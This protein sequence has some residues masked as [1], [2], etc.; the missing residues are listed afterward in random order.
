MGACITYH[1]DPLPRPACCRRSTRP[2]TWRFPGSGRR[3]R[4]TRRPTSR[5]QTR[6]SAARWRRP[7][8]LARSS[9]TTGSRAAPP[10]PRPWSDGGPRP[11]ALATPRAHRPRRGGAALHRRRSAA[12]RDPAVLRRDRRGPLRSVTAEPKRRESSS[13]IRPTGRGRSP[14]ACPCRGS[15]RNRRG[16]RADAAWADGDGRLS[17]QAQADRRGVRSGGLAPHRRC[18]RDRRRGLLPD[19]RSQEGD[20][21]QLDREEHRPGLRR[22]RD[23]ELQR[24]DR[25]GRLH[26]QRPALQHGPDRARARGDGGDT[27]E[28]DP[29]ANAAN[30]EVTCRDQIGRPGGEPGDEQARAGEAVQIVPG[31]WMPGGDELTP[32]MKLKRRPIDE[33]HAAAI[34]SLYDPDAGDAIDVDD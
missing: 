16:R 20:H 2:C 18:L 6:T 4:R 11:G 1:P 7:S 5:A 12:A 29:E 31:V 32:T 26:R 10:S 23:F 30:P 13:A 28:S 24:A 8:S 19:R 33:K 17:R 22:E 34:E 27:G 9:M 25:H 15:R 14:T 21:R 3:S